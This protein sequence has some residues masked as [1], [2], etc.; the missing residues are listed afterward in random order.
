NR[1]DYLVQVDSADAVR[2]LKPDMAA[3]ARV[4]MRGVMVTAAG[5][6]GTHDFVSRWFGP[7]VGVDED[8]VTG[9]SH[10]CLAPWWSERL[11]RRELLGYQASARGGTVGVR[12]VG[13]RVE[14]VGRA[15]TVLRGELVEG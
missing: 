8:P 14:L 1:F 2:S 13:D 11:G 4:D 12:L 3:L 10:C 6:E 15:V 5:D 9:S 7:G